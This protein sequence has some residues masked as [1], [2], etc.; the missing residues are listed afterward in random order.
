MLLA[1]DDDVS[2]ELGRRLL[3]RAGLVVDTVADSGE[4][5]RRA[6]A[7]DP[8][9]VV[10][11]TQ[12]PTLDRPAVARALPGRVTTPLV[13]VSAQAFREDRDACLDAGLDDHL[14]KPVP[15]DALYAVVLRCLRRAGDVTRPSPTSA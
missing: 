7:I 12:T 8:A 10:L 1:E 14:A 11:D 4:A 15:V 6:T 3:A 9:L 2:R 5:L 13:A